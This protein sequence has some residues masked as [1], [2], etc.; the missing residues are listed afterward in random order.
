MVSSTSNSELSFDLIRVD[1]LIDLIFFPDTETHASSSIL[2]LA[3]F[4]IFSIKYSKLRSNASLS[5][6]SPLSI[7]SVLIDRIDKISI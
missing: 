6:I 5:T 3:S 1:E 2:I 4:S 7:L